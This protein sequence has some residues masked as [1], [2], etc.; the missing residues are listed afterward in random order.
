MALS[1]IL[2]YSTFLRRLERTPALF[3][4]VQ[5]QASAPVNAGVIRALWSQLSTNQAT[6][7]SAACARN[8]AHLRKLVIGTLA[9]RDLSGQASLQEVELAMTALAE[10]A[11]AELLV[12]LQAA[13][14]ER[15]GTPRSADGQ[16]LGLLVI[17]MG[18]L[19][20]FELNVSSDIDVVF[21]IAEHGQTEREIDALEVFAHIAERLTRLL[22]DKNAEGFVFRVDTRLRPFGDAGPRVVTLD[23]LEH[24]FMAHGRFWE[25]CAWMKARIVNAHAAGDATT[26]LCEMVHAFVF[27]RYTD[28]T[29]ID[30]LS[31]LAAKIA[32]ERTRARN[33]AS[34]G[35]T[36]IKLGRGGIREIEFIVQSQAITHGG[37][38]PALRVP[39]TRTLLGLLASQGRM[40]PQTAERL[41][42][43]YVLLRRIEHA[44]QFEA[45]EQ[46]H[47]VPEDPA[48][49]TQLAGLLRFADLGH[50]DAELAA[51]RDFVAS[52]FEAL[53]RPRKGSQTRIRETVLSERARSWMAGAA[54]ESEISQQRFAQVLAAFDQAVPD[55]DAFSRAARFAQ[56][57]M[58]RRTYLD[59]LLAHP[60]VLRRLA[61]LI[62][63]SPFAAD[64]LTRHPILL[65]ELIDPEMGEA[66]SDWHEF[67][68]DLQQTL[69]ASNDAEA[70]VNALRDAH[71]AQVLRIL[72]RDL[73]GKLTVEQVSDEL[74]LLADKLLAAALRC[75]WQA[76]EYPGEPAGF[77]VIAYG[78][79]GAK[80]L[81]YT[82]DLDLVFLSDAQSEDEPERV[83]QL[84]RL[85]QRLISWLSMQTTSG[86]LFEVDTRL[87]PDGNAG[88]LVSSR[89]AFAQY[90]QK[91]ALWEHQALTRARCCAGDA[92][93]CGWFET[94]RRDIIAQPRQWLAVA[95][96]VEG[97][98]KRVLEGHPNRTELFDI[99][100]DPGGLVDMEFAVQ[101]LVLARAHERPELRDDVGTLALAMRAAA[102][103][104]VDSAIAAAACDA[105][106]T[107]RGLQ[108]TLR[109]Q[110]DVIARLPPQDAQRH[111]LAIERFVAA[112]GLNFP[113]A[114]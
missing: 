7:D 17:G 32:A 31:D 24:Y 43:A 111:R 54:R 103:G 8:L 80:E 28:Y 64:Y 14:F 70:R 96:E 57:I 106:R 45:D 94:F 68:A 105:Y 36:D 109:L 61:E 75:V 95:A 84:V 19:G 104:L 78:R 74:S 2:E 102:A 40:P 100:H 37:R 39:A 42:A 83:A 35:Q 65:D 33:Y 113:G 30:G 15:F 51:T 90:Q 34:F 56:T 1:D 48:K 27:R 46:T 44:L 9:I 41:D 21:A 77:A 3:A 55:D 58:R 92:A 107:L 6:G 25:R 63:A 101:A 72:A 79:L 98:R 23:A 5:S 81:G 89:Q 67:D 112:A 49:R 91:A 60:V 16:P 20:A 47:N 108:H 53:L 38:A 13:A 85:A 86:R 12:P 59:L 76:L 66:A 52:Q 26:R 114:R 22:A 18:K 50:F 11:V 87:R 110:A 82:S 62:A 97:M 73:A 69:Q 71:H 93:L 29:S 99:K 10:L 88:M 4:Q